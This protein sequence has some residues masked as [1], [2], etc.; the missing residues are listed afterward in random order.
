MMIFSTVRRGVTP[1]INALATIMVGIVTVCVVIAGISL[2]RQ[3]TRRRRDVQLA[4][5]KD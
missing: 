2:A 4:D 1:E 3:E 5:G